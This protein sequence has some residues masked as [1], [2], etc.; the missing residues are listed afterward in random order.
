ML[1]FAGAGH[2]RAA[3]QVFKLPFP[4]QTHV[5]TGGNA[6][7]DLGFVMLT[8]RFEI[9]HR[10]IA[11]QNTAQHLLILGSKFR[12]AFFNR[13]QIFRGEWT[14]K[15]KIVIKTVFNHRPNGDLRLRE[16]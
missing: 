8:Q 2:M 1:E 4:V 10:L 13:H 9:G 3:T 11:R 5:F 6:A 15:R 12:H 16:H 7:D 14:L